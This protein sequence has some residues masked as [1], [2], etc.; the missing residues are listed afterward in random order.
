MHIAAQHLWSEAM[1][2]DE[3]LVHRGSCELG[4]VTI[5]MF[6]SSPLRY[7]CSFFGAVVRYDI[8][9]GSRTS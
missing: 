8:F 3:N 9:E 4:G 6:R 5:L 2:L 1:P 7:C